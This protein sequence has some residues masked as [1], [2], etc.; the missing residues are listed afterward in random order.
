MKITTCLLLSLCFFSGSALALNVT[1]VAKADRG[2]KP[3]ITGVTNLPDGIDLMI[4]ISRKESQYMAQDKVK[5][6]A[7][8][9]RS[10][11]FS[12]KGNALN[13]GKYTIE[14]SMPIAA[15]QPPNTWPVIGNDGAKLEGPLVKKN[16]FGGKVVEYKTSMVIGSGE[17]SSERDNMAREQEQKDKHEWWL[18]SC[19]DTCRMTQGIAQKRGEA[20]NWDRCY[21]RCVAD[22]PN[23]KSP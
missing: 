17:A 20:F 2:S 10:A 9:F 8:T 3:T 11:E 22:E 16:S 4:T 18:R 23:M 19:T 7:G 6:K 1:L 5:V 15:V 13:P 21:Y 12:Q 14:M